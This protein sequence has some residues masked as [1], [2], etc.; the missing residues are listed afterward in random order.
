MKL[1]KYFLK[2]IVFCFTLFL[3]GYAIFIFMIQ[4]AIFFK[5]YYFLIDINKLINSSKNQV[6]FSL[7][8]WIL[9]I[10]GLIF[11]VIIAILYA[12]NSINSFIYLPTN[13]DGNNLKNVLLALVVIWVVLGSIAKTKNII[14]LNSFIIFLGIITTV[15]TVIP[16]NKLLDLIS[17]KSIL[18]KHKIDH[19]F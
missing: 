12:K 2:V 9:L 3:F 16:I 8:T 4:V 14:W 10:Y 15:N 6:N 7:G 18:M 11:T 13:K 17:N 5:Q 19:L 1:L